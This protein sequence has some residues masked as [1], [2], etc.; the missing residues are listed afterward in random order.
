VLVAAVIAAV[1]IG[2]VLALASGND[3]NVI[4]LDVGECFELPDDDD[5]LIEIVDPIDCDEP[6]DAQVVADGELNPD[7]SDDYPPDAE[8]F[9]EAD[10]MCF[11][12]LRDSDA[13]L[14]DFGVL[15]VVANEAAWAPK[16]GRFL[17]VAVPYGGEPRRGSIIDLVEPTDGESSGSA[18]ILWPPTRAIS[19]V[20]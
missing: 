9:A 8:L 6:H 3:T 15:P 16:Q 2:V 10:R 19:S 4:D 14:A 12:A 11:L 1:L 20:G 7:R 5:D 18:A 13:L 17:C